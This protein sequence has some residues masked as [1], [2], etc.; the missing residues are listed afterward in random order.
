MTTKFQYSTDLALNISS[1][2]IAVEEL[3]NVQTITQFLTQA[4]KLK[5]AG[6]PL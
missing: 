6:E 5:R 3:E 1:S 4:V 2:Q